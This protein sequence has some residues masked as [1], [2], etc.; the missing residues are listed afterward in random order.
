MKNNFL[1]LIIIFAVITACG[2]VDENETKLDKILDEDNYSSEVEYG[3]EESSADPYLDDGIASSADIDTLK[4]HL[5]AG[6]YTKVIS[7]DAT[8]SE[9]GKYYTGIAYY[10]LMKLRGRFSESRRAEYR[11]QAIAL[12][13]E[14]GEQ[15][16]TRSLRARALL[17]YAMALHLNYT[18]LYNNRVAIS[19]LR[20]I[21]DGLK[22]TDVYDDSYLVT[23]LIYTKLG[24]YIQAR[25]HYKKLKTINSVDNRVWD[26]E[27]KSFYSPAEAADV[28]LERVRRICFPEDY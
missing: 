10:C 21:Q 27:S 12:L 2:T 24:W 6:Y 14:V 19:A 7:M 20:L 22:D 9:A 5:R 25:V 13:K 26:P 1:L 23:A 16:E 4:R 8:A 17:W 15:A 28:G 11:D 3:E 18:D